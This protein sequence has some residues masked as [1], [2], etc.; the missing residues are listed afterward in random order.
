M[1]RLIPSVIYVSVNV[2][3]C[4]VHE[5]DFFKGSSSNT[6]STK[7]VCVT[8]QLQEKFHENKNIYHR[9]KFI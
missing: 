7:D 3:A 5:R 1:K 4:S 6:F 9:D 2:C 8:F